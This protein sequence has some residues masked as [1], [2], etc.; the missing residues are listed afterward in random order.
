M[1]VSIDDE[2]FAGCLAGAAAVRK[3]PIG[4]HDTK[5]KRRQHTTNPPIYHVLTPRTSWRQMGWPSNRNAEEALKLPKAILYEIYAN[6]IF[7]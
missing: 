6:M 1:G 2:G 5:Q 7:F 3:R 4:E